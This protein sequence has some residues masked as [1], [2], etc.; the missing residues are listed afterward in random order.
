LRLGVGALGSIPGWLLVPVGFV[1]LVILRST[2]LALG[3]AKPETASAEKR[4]VV[5]MV[6]ANSILSMTFETA[7]ALGVGMLAGLPLL[8]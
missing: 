1:V 7:W 5:R 8:T 6:K 2:N 4:K 3:T